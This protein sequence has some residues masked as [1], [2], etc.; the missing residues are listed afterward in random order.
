MGYLLR[1]ALRLWSNVALGGVIPTLLMLATHVFRVVQ[2]NLAQVLGTALG[3]YR[4]FLNAEYV[5]ETRGVDVCSGVGL[6]WQE[7]LGV[8]W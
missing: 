4:W 7:G 8:C 3:R 5:Y 1:A 2:A 6:E